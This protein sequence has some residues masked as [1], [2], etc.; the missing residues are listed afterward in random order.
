[1]P[2][3]NPYLSNCF[4]FQP[5]SHLV[6]PM[7]DY[8]MPVNTFA[9]PLSIRYWSLYSSTKTHPSLTSD[10]CEQ[11]NDL[12]MCVCIYTSTCISRFLPK[13]TLVQL[14]VKF[15]LF[16]MPLKFEKECKERVKIAILW[17]IHQILIKAGL[18]MAWSWGS[19]TQFRSSMGSTEFTYLNHYHSLSRLA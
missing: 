5:L 4:A 18:G 8:A 3:I 19:G 15:L 9:T 1:M 11:L 7:M 16:K 13:P 17:F 14:E 12:K 10:W 2:L 6:M